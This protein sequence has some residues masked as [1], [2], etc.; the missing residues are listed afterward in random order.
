MLRRF[1]LLL[2]VLAGAGFGTHAMAE[3]LPEHGGLWLEKLLL[4]FF[5]VL[6]AWISAGFWTGLLGAW[7][8]LRR[9]R[10]GPGAARS[11]ALLPIDVGVRTAIVMPICNESVATVF[12]GLQATLD[13]LRET[14]EA[15]R[16]D[17]FVLSDSSAA[18]IRVAEQQAWA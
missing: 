3:V 17:V 4:V 7:V 11:G 10:S 12:G 6:F 2:L 16:F 15:S 8:L 13:S 18:D 1:M 5:G 14:G 9:G